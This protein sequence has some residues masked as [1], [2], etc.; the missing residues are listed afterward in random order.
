M[1][2]SHGAAPKKSASA[3]KRASAGKSRPQ[4]DGAAVPVVVREER[5]RQVAYSFYEQRGYND[6]LELDDWLKAEEM[7]DEEPGGD[8]QALASAASGH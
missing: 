4:P 2:I 6:G 1:H 7:V 5:I 8:L 3:P